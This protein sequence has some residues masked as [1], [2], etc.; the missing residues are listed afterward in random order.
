MRKMKIR[1]TSL[2]RTTELTRTLQQGKKVTE[3]ILKVYKLTSVTER[4][5]RNQLF[6]VS[7]KTKIEELEVVLGG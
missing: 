5:N 1:M 3:S 2:R 6:T 4:V 7:A